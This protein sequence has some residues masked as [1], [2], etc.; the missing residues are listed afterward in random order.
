MI[1]KSL[2]EEML[3]GLKVRTYISWRFVRKFVGKDYTNYLLLEYAFSGA[4]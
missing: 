3:I 1:V 2:M 4:S